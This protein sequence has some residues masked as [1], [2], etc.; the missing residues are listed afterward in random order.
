MR[1]FGVVKRSKA[2]PGVTRRYFWKNLGGILDFRLVTLS[3]CARLWI[4]P[5]WPVE[6]SR[7]FG[8][9]KQPFGGTRRD[10][11]RL[12]GTRC[13]RGNFVSRLVGDVR[14]PGWTPHSCSAPLRNRVSPTRALRST[15]KPP[16]SAHGFISQGLDF[17]TRDNPASEYGVCDE[18]IV[19]VCD[20]QARMASAG[21]FTLCNLRRLDK[22]E[23]RPLH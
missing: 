15:I 13:R 11:V 2:L 16:A 19:S 21:R 8:G 22:M 14:M 4:C 23:G 1:F 9:W 7:I 3:R 6:K 12:G 5:D 20:F 18:F 17:A 10:L